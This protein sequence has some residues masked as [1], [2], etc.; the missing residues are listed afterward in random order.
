MKVS[1]HMRSGNVIT[2]R[3]IKN[4]EIRTNGNE[5]VGITLE[6]NWLGRAVFPRLVVKS[7]NL[8]QIDAVLVGGL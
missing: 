5:V 3:G 2:M 7:L 6:R 4:W 1:I 8:Q